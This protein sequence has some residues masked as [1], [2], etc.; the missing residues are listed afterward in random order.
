MTAVGAVLVGRLAGATAEG[1]A[2]VAE[3][4]AAAHAAI[5]RAPAQDGGLRRIILSVYDVTRARRP[6]RSARRPS[7]ANATA[8]IRIAAI[9]TSSTRKN[10]NRLPANPSGR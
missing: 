1:R 2:A 7:P 6:G 8:P 4:H 5:S 3:P 10:P 9:G